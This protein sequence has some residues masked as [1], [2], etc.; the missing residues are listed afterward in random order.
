[1]SGRATLT[2]IVF[3]LVALGFGAAALADD[4]AADF[5][6]ADAGLEA[7]QR[8]DF[9]AAL[10]AWLPLARRGDA[11]AQTWIG[12]MH[13]EGRG[14][15]KDAAEA[16]RWLGRAASRNYAEA[17]FR[18]GVIHEFGHGIDEDKARAHAFYER[19]ANHAHVEAQL[20]LS[21]LYEFGI[22][23]AVDLV[24]A[25]MWSDIAKRT[26]STHAERVVAGGNLDT[27]AEL[28][29]PGQISEARWR[30]QSWIERQNRGD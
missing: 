23:T 3:G 15:A 30:A 20:R 4:N 28:M 19:A 24:R 22:G 25:Y 11:R 14:V 12:I 2:A 6:R 21:E 27:L 17:E 18:L 16:I 1:M 7:Y 8:L 5:R 10:G 13:G 26:A 9:A 29:T